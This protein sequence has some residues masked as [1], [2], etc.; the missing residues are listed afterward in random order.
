VPAA[1]QSNLTASRASESVRHAE[2]DLVTPRLDVLPSSQRLLRD[3]LEA[4][5]RTF[6]LYGAAALALR[7]GHRASE[8]FDFTTDIFA[9]EELLSRIPYLRDGAVVKLSPEQVRTE[10]TRLQA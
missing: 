3:E 9:S 8:D 1:W 10:A 5:P 6:V 4:T 2:V 7:L